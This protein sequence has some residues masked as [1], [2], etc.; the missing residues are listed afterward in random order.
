MPS[1]NRPLTAGR[2][3]ATDDWTSVDFPSF[4][5]SGHPVAIASA[6]SFN[7]WNPMD[8][9]V[10]GIGRDGMSARLEEEASGDSEMTHKPEDLSILALPPGPI[11][12][13]GGEQIGEAGTVSESQ[14]DR[15]HW[16][17]L[18][19]DESY[20]DP[21]VFMKI[22]TKNGRHPVHV[23]LQNV[24]G[25]GCEFQPEGWNYLNGPHTDEELGYVVLEAGTH[26]LPDGT[27]LHVDTLRADD[28]WNH[29]DFAPDFKN[30]QPA[31]ATQAQTRRGTHEIVT[32]T[33]DLD[34]HDLRARVQEEQDRDGEHKVE[35]RAFVAV[36]RPGETVDSLR[37]SE[38]PD[39]VVDGFLPSTCG[40]QFPNDFPAGQYTLPNPIRL[41]APLPDI[42]EIGDTTNGMCGRMVFVAR[43]YFECGISGPRSR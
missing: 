39:T 18:C 9:R 33:T 5:G 15:D 21:V 20:D 7:G 36:A 37:V 8:V 28:E 26:E 30:K 22:Q 40:F 4:E 31:I 42:T 25:D 32:R 24:D 43:D 41:P 27:N 35:E 34:A 3:E 1:R 2:F 23:R 38:V 29:A 19:F 10:R 12:N 16:H 17:T 13:E 11:W 6:T 14:P